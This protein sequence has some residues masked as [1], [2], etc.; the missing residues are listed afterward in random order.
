MDRAR[1]VQRLNEADTHIA[2]AE[3]ALTK[4]LALI[5]KL[6]ADCRDTAEAISQL[7]DFE[8]ILK[9]LREHRATIVKTIEQIDAGLV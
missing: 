4:Q 1:E 5:T 9:V 6:K 3:R 7:A 2:K 8:A